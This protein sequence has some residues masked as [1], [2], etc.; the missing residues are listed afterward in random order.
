[1]LDN[2]A[3]EQEMKRQELQSLEQNLRSLQ[4]RRQ[5]AG[6]GLIYQEMRAVSDGS[7]AATE[8]GDRGKYSRTGKTNW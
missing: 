5:N 7:M 2:Q 8:G 6:D 1:M 4:Q 3:D